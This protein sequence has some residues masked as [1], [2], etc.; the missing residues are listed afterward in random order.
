[1]RFL[2]LV[3]SA[4]IL[5]P[6]PGA[7]AQEAS[8]TR[9]LAGVTP[10]SL[11]GKD[12]GFRQALSRAEAIYVGEIHDRPGDHRFEGRLIEILARNRVPFVVGW[13]MFDRSQ[14]PVLDAWQRGRLTRAQLF[15]QTGFQRAW[16]VYSP[17]YGRILDETRRFGIRNLALNARPALAHKVSQGIQMTPAEAAEV[18][19]GFSTDEGAFRNFSRMMGA[20]PGMD[21][22]SLRRFFKAQ[23]LW[24]QT[25]ASV[26]LD[27]HAREPQTKVVVLTGRGH[28]ERGYGIPYF[29]NQKARLEQLVLLP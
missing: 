3:L 19:R 26:I 28:V 1:M 17:W 29:V 6:L 21:T 23:S 25:M 14:Q 16:A 13:E 10:A 11:A 12:A 7:S 27:F 2:A 15:Q 4:V 24:D 18:P 9:V 22:N 5:L 8:G 20:H